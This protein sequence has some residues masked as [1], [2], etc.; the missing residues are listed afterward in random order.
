MKRTLLALALAFISTIAFSQEKIAVFPFEDM[1]NLLT[2]SESVLFY[3]DF[4]NEFATKTAGKF[5]VVPRQ[6]VE[7]LIDTEA[8]FQMS[9]YSERAKTAEW[10]K[11]LNGTQILSG[12]IGKVD[13]N[14]RIT[15]SLYTYPDLRILPSGASRSVTNK[16]QLF[17]IIP[18]LVQSM[19]S[20]IT[21]GNRNT[22]GR[23]YKIGDT[24]PAG[25]IIFYD[26][27][28]TGDGWRYLEAAPAGSEFSAKWGAYQKD[29]VGTEFSVGSGKRN[30]QLIVE[31][32]KVL[33]ENNCAAQICA[34]MDINGYSDWFLPSL[35]E[36][37]LMYKNLEQK[38]LAEFNGVWY[39]SSSQNSNT[40]YSW[41]HRFLPGDHESM[42]KFMEIAV[43]A[44]RAF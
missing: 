44:I 5:S 43:R 3:R 20:A 6:D 14:I 4:C 41:Y 35:F 7:K 30:T 2:R 28:F 33:G 38:G 19:M 8:S 29:V 24:G 40:G 11:V 37:D 16:S 42:A 12:V 26:R 10:E 27:G 1:D 17:A 31:R 15:V 21:E 18:E 36:L 39:W 23:T 25:G 32:L 22:P 9:L 34:G 13:N